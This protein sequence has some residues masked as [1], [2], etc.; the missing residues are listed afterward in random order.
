MKQSTKAYVYLTIEA[1]KALFVDVYH[2]STIEACGVLLGTI[3]EQ[4]NWHVEA[5]YPLRN[6]FASPVYFEFAPEDLLMVEMEHPDRIVG[7]YHSHPTGFAEA[8][9]TDRENMKRVNTE[10]H[11]PWVWC[12]IRGPFT[13]ASA[14][15]REGRIIPPSIIA[16]H[17]YEKERLQKISIVPEEA[18]HGK[19]SQ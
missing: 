17:H 4:G 15:E 5:A 14:Q 3:N 9:S 8:S 19:T 6:I 10:Q 7:V 13:E 12:I 2:R 1:Q 18:Q 11:I 16:Y